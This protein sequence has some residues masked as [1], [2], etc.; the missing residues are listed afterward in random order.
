MISV[1]DNKIWDKF[2]RN[3]KFLSRLLKLTP[4][5][6]SITKK[7]KYLNLQKN[8]KILDVGCGTGKL[9]S[10]WQKNGYDVIGVDISDK[11][12][13]ITNGF[14]VK[15]IKADVLKKLPFEDNTFDLVYSDGLLEHFTN[16]NLIIKEKFRVSKNYIF[17]IVPGFGAIK[18]M[19]DFIV[20]PPKEY[21][22]SELEWAK[23]HNN[24]KPFEIKTW[25]LFA[26]I[27][28]LCKKTKK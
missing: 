22:R 3:K 28:I 14:N 5:Y 17:T 20:R 1:E 24:F 15:T 27:V 25:K 9:A 12:L 6:K 7:F 8:S 4:T 13:K 10:F 21:K 2:W 26:T 23:L 19:I 18:K 16:P 11:A